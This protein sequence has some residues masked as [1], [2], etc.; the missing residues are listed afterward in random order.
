MRDASEAVMD[1]LN[2]EGLRGDDLMQALRSSRRG[3]WW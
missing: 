1:S 3:F 2:A